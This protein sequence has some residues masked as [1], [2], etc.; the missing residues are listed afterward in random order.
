MGGGWAVCRPFAI[1]IPKV[2]LGMVVSSE[3]VLEFNAEVP[4]F[5]V[6][7]DFGLA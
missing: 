7:S 6:D 3:L 4:L 2:W 1:V 5:I